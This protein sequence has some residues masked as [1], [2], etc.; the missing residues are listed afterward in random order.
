M[1][2]STERS[3]HL[4]NQEQYQLHPLLFILASKKV[5]NQVQSAHQYL[6]SIQGVQG[7]SKL[8]EIIRCR[9]S[10]FWKS[11]SD[12]E[13]HLGKRKKLSQRLERTPWGK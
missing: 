9:F 8:I 4:K 11:R 13:I 6:L 5:L 1:L 3:M 12:G 2:S 10:L 7:I